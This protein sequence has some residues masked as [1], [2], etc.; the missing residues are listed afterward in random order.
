MAAQALFLL[1]EDRDD[2]VLLIKRAF[3]KAN[4]LNPLH[5]VSTG[6]EA[7]AYLRGVGKYR[8]RQEFP[9]PSLVLLDIKMPGLDGFQVLE[10]IREDPDLR[11]LRVVILTSSDDMHDVNRAYK[12]GANSFLIKPIDFERFVEI[13]Q[14]LAGYWLWMNQAPEVIRPAESGDARELLINKGPTSYPPPRRG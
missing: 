6:E 1:V 2:D 14:A 7:I 4:V 10:W 9:L 11:A 12:L 5:V 3:I 13:S 8:N